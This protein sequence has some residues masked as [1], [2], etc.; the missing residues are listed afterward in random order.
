VL[1]D[2]PFS[3]I[4]PVYVEKLL[5]LIKEEKRIKGILISDHLYR[6]VM[7]VADRMYVLANGQTYLVT[8]NRHLE[9]YLPHY[10]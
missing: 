10:E 7:E 2:E 5:D 3:V 1:L 6:Q 8:D 9:K 4:M